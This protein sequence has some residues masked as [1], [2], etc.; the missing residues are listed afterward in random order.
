MRSARS[1]ASLRPCCA[2][3]AEMNVRK[4]FLSV[5]FL[6]CLLAWSSAIAEREAP[7]VRTSGTF[8]VKLAPQ[9]QDEGPSGGSLG[10]MTIDKQ[11]KG[12]LEGT[13]K[14]EM[15]TGM[16]GVKESA[17]YVAIERVT[18]TLGGR[19]GTFMLQHHGLMTRGAQNLT[20]IVVPDS[21]TEDLVG[22]D[23][24]MTIRIDGG[25]HFYD[26]EYSLSR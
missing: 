5:I 14:G 4:T 17:G 22:L 26:F 3:I 24:K 18:G 21:G 25:K 16:T 1:V 9:A 7:I 12:D 6:V 15:L 20:I 10:R 2:I 13:S 8:D 23:G 11:F 19:R